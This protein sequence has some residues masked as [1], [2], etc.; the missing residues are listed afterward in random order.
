M[1]FLKK[2][3]SKVGQVAANTAEAHRL[4]CEVLGINFLDYARLSFSDRVAVE[5]AGMAELERRR[6]EAARRRQAAQRQS[7][8]WFSKYTSYDDSTEVLI[9]RDGQQTTE[10]PHVHVI[11]DDSRSEVRII[12]SRSKNN[13]PR[14]I[15]LPA[16]SSPSEIDAAV[17]QLRQEL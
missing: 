1:S 11:Y 4:G 15:T 5:K 8:L 12:L 10:Y 6:E 9:G 16:S 17:N 13:H 2:V 7:D 14:R 3:A